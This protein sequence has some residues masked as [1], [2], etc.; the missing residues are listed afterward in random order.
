M[1]YPELSGA[2]IS[3]RDKAFAQ[4]F[5]NFVNGSMCSPDQTGREL[6]RAHRYL[7]QQMFK[8]FIGFMKQ[9][10]YNYQQG[11]YDDRNEYG[12]QCEL[13]IPWRGYH[14]GTIVALSEHGF[15]VQFSS[16]AEIDVYKDEIIL[17]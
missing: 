12:R 11:R 4:E 7:Q 3:E 5:A 2:T 14:R 15:V 1:D 6:T 17:D 13:I 9:L 8:V 16:G 10:A